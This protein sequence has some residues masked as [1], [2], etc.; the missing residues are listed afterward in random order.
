MPLY[1]FEC[2]NCGKITESTYKIADCPEHIKCDYCGIMAQKIISKSAIQCDSA[3]DVS[4]LKSAE[5][6][7]KPAHERSWESRK[8]YKEC[9]QR[10]NLIP[11]G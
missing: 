2:Y 1:E 10:N 6:V 9:L 5:E 4:W 11:V 8:D 3:N 7:I